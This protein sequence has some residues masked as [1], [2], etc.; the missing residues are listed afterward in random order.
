MAG[1]IDRII[2]GPSHVYGGPT[3]KEVYKTQIPYDPE[4]KSK[5]YIVCLLFCL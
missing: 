1:Y 2:L 3:C 5:N 4:G